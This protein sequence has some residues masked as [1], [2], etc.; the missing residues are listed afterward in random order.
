MNKLLLLKKEGLEIETLVAILSLSIAVLAMSFS[1]IFIKISEAEISPNSTVFNRLW[2][3]TLVLGI[4]NVARA[5]Y[6]KIKHHQQS[7]KQHEKT[8]ILTIKT[9]GFLLLTAVA[10]VAFQSTWAWS[11]AQTSVA[12]STVLH[13]MT[14]VFTSLGAWL[15]FRKRFDRIFSLGIVLSIGG[16]VAIGFEDWQIATGKIQGDFGA[17]ISAIFYAGYILILEQLSSRLNATTIL[18]WSSLIGAAILLP[19][20]QITEDQ[21]FP[22]SWQGWLAVISLALICQ[23]IGQILVIY[24]LNQLSASF[25]AL[26]I[27]LDPLLSAIEAWIIFS[28]RLSF[29]SWMGFS[30]VLVGIYISTYSKSVVKQN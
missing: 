9:L 10:F 17:L 13:N 28:E 18:M 20:I 2:I 5:I 14:P 21:L 27:M 1:A 8:S 16:V 7:D 30:L 6:L 12:I 15:I 24:S 19:I 26:F 3:A 23:V 4:W 22:S 29:F 25:V 11:L